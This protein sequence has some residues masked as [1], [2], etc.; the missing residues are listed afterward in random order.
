MER[1]VGE[2]DGGTQRELKQ[3]RNYGAHSLRGYWPVGKRSSIAM[4][5]ELCLACGQWEKVELC[6]LNN[7]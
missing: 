2:I 1:L 7:A 3:Q 4:Q 5:P 6:N